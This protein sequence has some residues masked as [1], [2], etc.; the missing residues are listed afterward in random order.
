[1]LGIAK[2]MGVDTHKRDENYATSNCSG[3]DLNIYL[4][5]SVET[6]YF[7]RVSVMTPFIPNEYEECINLFKGFMISNKYD[8]L[9]T[10]N[11]SQHFTW[12]D[13]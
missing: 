5:E 9:N 2:D 4:A 1:M 12:Y 6:E 7:M 13:E 3:T 10:V 8:S 11:I